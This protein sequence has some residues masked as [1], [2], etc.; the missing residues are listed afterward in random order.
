MKNKI[1]LLVTLLICVLSFTSALASYTVSLPAGS[2]VYVDPGYYGDVAETLNADG[3]FTITE[4]QRDAAGNL[5]GKLKSGAGWVAL[6]SE[7]YLLP[8]HA[9]DEI[10]AGPGYDFAIVD[11]LTKDGTFTIVASAWDAAGNLW[12]KLKSGAGWVFLKGAS[13]MVYLPI[14]ADFATEELIAKGPYEYI[15][16]DSS[17]N[18]TEIAIYANE[19]LTDV[20]FFEHVHDDNGCSEKPLAE[21]ETVTIEKPVVAAVAFY[22]DNTVYG[23]AFTDEAG[24]E[25]CFDISISGM[26]GS[27]L[28]TECAVEHHIHS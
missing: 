9:G 24:M 6:S 14:Y 23:I 3:T 27:L 21:L 13:A 4:E 15:L 25:R 20:C 28:L 22:G 11:G 5:W 8:L 19:T 18:A 2:T 26:D 16:V 1:C 10:Y 7:N 12:G 17:L